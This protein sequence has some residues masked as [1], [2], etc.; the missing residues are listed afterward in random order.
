ML[1][2][3]PREECPLM[4]AVE[5]GIES[6]NLVIRP[7]EGPRAGWEEDFRRMAERGDDALVD[8]DTW[9]TTAWDDEEW[10]W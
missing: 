4:D 5:P 6:E 2:I 8:G 1:P 3:A 9:G 7:A 10:E